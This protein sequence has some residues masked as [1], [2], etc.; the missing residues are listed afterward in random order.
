MSFK[1]NITFRLVM[2]S[3]IGFILFLISSVG[4]LIQIHA[5]NDS[6]VETR[7]VWMV[8]DAKL[9]EI[10]FLVLRYHTTTIR[11]VVAV[12]EGE[13]RDLDGEF[14]EMDRII[15]ERF[16]QYRALVGS[17][18]ET[19]LWDMLEGR[20]KA[21]L[22][23]R[24]AIVAALARGDRTA[25]RDAIAPARPP[26][27]ATFEALG[28]LAKV[29]AEGTNAS[30][31]RAEEAFRTAWWVT[32]AL[33]IAGVVTTG[34]AVWWVW[35]HVAWPIRSMAAVM[36]RLAADDLD[37]VVAGSERQDEIG[38]MAAAVQVF[39]DNLIRTR[40]LE[41]ETARARARPRSS[42]RAGM[43]QMADGFEG[44][45][46]G[47]IGMV[48]SSATELQA[49]ARDHDRHAPPRPPSQSTH[50]GGRRR[51]GRLQRQHRGGGRRGAGLVGPGDRPAGRGLG[52]RSPRRAVARGRP[53][54]RPGAGAER[55]GGR[56]SATWSA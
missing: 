16:G 48:S 29:N 14:V 39:K 10:Q 24:A 47:I 13:N 44:A 7:D 1:R 18:R 35:R 17:P 41:A 26:L 12:D 34:A 50:G 45:V 33:S 15:P 51:G 56:G 52:R 4:N 6:A 27:V 25:A 37:V 21:Y 28:D 11:K 20:W 8:K 54:R 31:R 19:A 46:G 49:T 36:R 2:P 40:T 32:V 30:V 22:A 5:I 55:R 23:A 53:D 42:A 38:A 43:R 9:N 3:L